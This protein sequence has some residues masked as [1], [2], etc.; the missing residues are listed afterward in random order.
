VPAFKVG[1]SLQPH[2][3]KLDDLRR[4]WR[5]AD[6]MGLDS[7]W[8]WDH[9]YPLSG[10]P[11]G[12]SYE[13][14]SLLAA[15]ATDTAHASI[16]L[17]VA[18]TAYRNADVYAHAMTTVDHLSAGRVVL[19][20]GAGWF[21]RDFD[22]YGLEFGTPGDRLRRLEHDLRRIKARLQ[23]LHPSPAG[24]M[25]I[26]IGGGGEKVTLR[27]VA[28]HADIW[29]SFGPPSSYRRKVRV[30]DEWCAR[31][32]RDPS[33]IERSANLRDPSLDDVRGMV[34]AGCQHLVVSTAPPYDLGPARR[35]LELAR[36]TTATSA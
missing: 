10:N 11:N 29:N 36:A 28:E 31:V 13:A 4:A 1:V 20:I 18:C 6:A 12:N 3:A 23:K 9:F 15:M 24:R 7:I 14:V 30:L 34:E 25:P 17:M 16:G 19:G 5:E 27:L 8:V 26:C 21:Q 35:A 22:E 33:E 2:H 32:G